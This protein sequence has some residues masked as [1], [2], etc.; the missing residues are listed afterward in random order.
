VIPFLQ[1]YHEAPTDFRRYTREGMRQ[2]GDR[3]GL[4]TVAL[5]PVHTI[6]QTLG[7]ILWEYLL[8]RD[9]SA[10]QAVFWPFIWLATRWS[11]RS[12][13]ARSRTANA[14]QSVYLK[15]SN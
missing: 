3:Y 8:E 14:F 11:C 2:L 5:Y 10:L 9:N 6:A 1:P 7:W 15:S 13:L 12:D 4:E